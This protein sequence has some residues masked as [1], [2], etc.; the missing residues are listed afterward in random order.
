MEVV[1][2]GC[3]GL[4]VVLITKCG[5]KLQVPSPVALNCNGDSRARY[6]IPEEAVSKNIYLRNPPKIPV[7]KV[8][9]QRRSRERRPPD[10]RRH[11]RRC[12]DVPLMHIDSPQAQVFFH[13]QGLAG[14]SLRDHGFTLTNG[15]V[16]YALDR[17]CPNKLFKYLH[18]LNVG[19]ISV[20]DQRSKHEFKEIQA[21]WSSSSPLKRILVMLL[22]TRELGKCPFYNQTQCH[23]WNAVQGMCA[24]F[25][26]PINPIFHS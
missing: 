16:S 15:V 20:I 2:A 5:P 3:A 23:R 8:D 10:L 13:T 12:F 4:G 7:K 21:S 14:L 26:Q 17:G 22:N 18:Y 24:I 25:R 9:S 19:N 1:N 6:D 11:P